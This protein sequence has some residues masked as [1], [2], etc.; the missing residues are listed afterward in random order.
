MIEH[1]LPR[2]TRHCRHMGAPMNAGTRLDDLF[3]RSAILR[4][5]RGLAN[6]RRVP[7]LELG[8]SWT[9][10]QPDLAGDAS[11]QA[12]RGRRRPTRNRC[13]VIWPLQPFGLG[14]ALH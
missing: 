13:S 2:G 14:V 12:R 6:S 7:D 4:P 8:A 3:A 9:T 11:R 10:G 1:L 5:R